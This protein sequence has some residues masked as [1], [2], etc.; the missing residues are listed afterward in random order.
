M[1]LYIYNSHYCFVFNRCSYLMKFTELLGEFGARIFEA[2]MYAEIKVFILSFDDFR[3]YC[4]SLLNDG[5]SL[6]CRVGN[7]NMRAATDINIS[8]Y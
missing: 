5:L 4:P 1:S 8:W 3:T 6:M 2:E 7:C